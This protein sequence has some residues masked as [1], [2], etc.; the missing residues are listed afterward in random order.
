MNEDQIR[1]LISADVVTAVRGSIPE[2]FRSSK[3]AMIELFD[4]HHATLS[5]ATVAATT[6]VVA[7]AGVRGERAF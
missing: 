1:E 5:K 4:D 2:L 3:T 7:A 6:T